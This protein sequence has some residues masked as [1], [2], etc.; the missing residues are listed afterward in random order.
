[1]FAWLFLETY[2]LNR[3]VGELQ[4][5]LESVAADRDGLQQDLGRA[6]ERLDGDVGRVNERLDRFLENGGRTGSR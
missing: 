4:K 5:Q 2:A 3:E 1:M 6:E